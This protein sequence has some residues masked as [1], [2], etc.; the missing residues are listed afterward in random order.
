MATL[1]IPQ[2][3]QI[4][5][6]AGIPNGMPVMLA[7][8]IALAE[9]SGRTDA[10]NRNTN[11][12]GDY[13][14]WQINDVHNEKMPGRDRFDPDVNAQ[15]MAMISSNGTNWQPWTTYN[16]G[17]Y[18]QFMGQVTSELGGTALV[19]GP[20][21]GGVGVGGGNGFTA[22]NA[23]LVTNAQQV[24]SGM[25]AAVDA[26]EMFFR[27][28]TSA[29]GWIRILKV[30]CGLI[31]I[32]TGVVLVVGT[33]GIGK[34]AMNLIPMGKVAKVAKVATAGAAVAKK[35]VTPSE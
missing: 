3:A 22:S 4:A 5:V 2:I 27:L 33:S 17:A 26:L 7:V 31:A 8:C 19:P 25:G 29:E 23:S 10:V 16:T 14:V 24:S 28:I 12:T 1:T 32:G 20:S 13:G 6:N 21:L 18:Q 30:G 11:G 34:T 35:E 15:L 9:S